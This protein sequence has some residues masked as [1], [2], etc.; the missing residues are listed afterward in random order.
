MILNPLAALVLLF[1]SSGSEADEASDWPPYGLTPRLARVA[2]CE[3]WDFR[4]DVV[5]GPTT[6]AA[7]EIG[8]AQLHPR[9]LLP[10]FYRWGYTN[11]WNPWQASAFMRDAFDLGMWR[12]WSCARQLGITSA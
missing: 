5:F 7:G 3:S 9:G 11:P 8:L 10:T 6:G 4:P 2:A 12:H 1:S